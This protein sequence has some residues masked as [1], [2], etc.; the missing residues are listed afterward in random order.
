[1]HRRLPPLNAVKAFEAAA[2]LESF[3]AAADELGVTH[4]AVSRQVRALE[5][6]FG[7]PLFARANRKVTLT[8]EGREYRD[9]ASAVLDRLSVATERLA[10][11]RGIHVLQICAPETFSVRWLIPRLSAFARA[12]PNI[13]VRIRPMISVEDHLKDTF[14]LVIARRRMDRPGYTST[15]FLG[16]TCVPVISPRLLEQTPLASPRALRNHTLL[17]AESVEHLWPDWLN[18]AGIGDLQPA[19]QLR[20]Q[21]LNYVLQAA[22]EGVGV[23]MGPSALVA[24]DLISGRLVAPLPEPVLTLGDFH[25]MAPA[26]IRPH[27]PAAI[28][29][30]WLIEEQK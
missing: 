28:F 14:D 12:Y 5:D 26:D 3:S 23:A 27:D 1:M 19:R 9:Q 30:R 10:G 13:E 29:R 4:G 17:H 16:E 11:P 8:R 18:A 2:R 25:V 24:D 7:F 20:F 22:V 6:W 21:S 15:P